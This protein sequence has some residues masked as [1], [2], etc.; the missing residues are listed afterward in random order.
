[1]VKEIQKHQ[2][3]HG[4]SLYFENVIKM[5]K[6]A[7]KQKIII[8]SSKFQRWWFIV[9]GLGKTTLDSINHPLNKNFE[10]EYI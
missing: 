5:W 4:F 7:T 6:I 2:N 9:I 10:F 1:M 8:T 3:F